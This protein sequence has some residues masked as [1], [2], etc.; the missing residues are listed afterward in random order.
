MI[1]KNNLIS[2]FGESIHKSSCQIY[3]YVHIEEG[4]EFSIDA[5]LKK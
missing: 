4:L 2:E 5:L 1:G 3:E